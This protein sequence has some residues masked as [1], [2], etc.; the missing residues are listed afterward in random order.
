MR[1]KRKIN[2]FIVHCS[3]TR[4]GQHID[5]E[6]IRD[7]H[8]NERGWSDIGYHYVI[9]LDGTIHNGRDVRRSGAHTKGQNTNSIG[10]CYIGGVESDGKTSKDTRTDAQKEGLSMLLLDLK[11]EHCDGVVHGH[12]DFSSKDCPSFD[13]TEEY[14]YISECYG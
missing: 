7:W 14:K 13:A 12:R 6:T 9:Y 8:V 4:E 10:I 11:S 2:K 1:K 5:V 3:A